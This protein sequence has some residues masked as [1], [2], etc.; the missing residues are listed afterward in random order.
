MKGTSKNCWHAGFGGSEIGVRISLGLLVFQ[1]YDIRVLKTG[2]GIEL[3]NS[4]DPNETYRLSQLPRR[5][6]CGSA[7]TRL[8]GLRVWIQMGAWMVAPCVVCCQERDLRR[9]DHSS[10]GVLSSVVCL[11]VISLPSTMRRPRPTGAVEPWKIIQIISS[12]PQ[13]NCN[14]VV[15]S[16]LCYSKWHRLSKMSPHKIYFCASSFPNQRYTSIHYSYDPSNTRVDI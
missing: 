12:S 10:I 9:A 14:N 7:T 2:F 1:C 13:S 3:W 8:L 16:L 6:R 5:L 15:E 4:D 11:N